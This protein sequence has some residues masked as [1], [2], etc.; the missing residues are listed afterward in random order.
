MEGGANRVRQ[1]DKGPYPGATP[2]PLPLKTCKGKSPGA[3]HQYDAGLR[4]CPEC[5]RAAQARYNKSDKRRAAQ[6][7]AQARYNKSDKGRAARAR[8]NKS[9]AQRAAQARYDKSDKR[10]AARARYNKSDKGRAA[11]RIRCALYRM[12][13]RQKR[14]ASDRERGRRLRATPEGRE[15]NRAECARRR[16]DPVKREAYNAARR[17]KGPEFWAALAA[18]EVA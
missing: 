7:A 6:R 14:L 3:P 1:P 4:Q 12:R 17:V 15:A 2:G 11:Q 10:R 9:A 5:K 8:Y 16:A 18:E 13:H